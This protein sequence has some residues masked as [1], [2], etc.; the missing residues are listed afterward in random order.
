MTTRQVLS[1]F[2]PML[3]ICNTSLHLGGHVG[4]MIVGYVINQ[5]DTLCVQ[6]P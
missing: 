3:L 1:H 5:F 6:V 2:L 4:M